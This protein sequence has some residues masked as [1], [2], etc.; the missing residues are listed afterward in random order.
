M[1]EQKQ[2]T[3]T[4]ENKA[5]V[6]TGEPT[7]RPPET[8]PMGV[9]L[10]VLERLVLLNVLPKEGNFTTIKLLRK[11]RENL[12]FDE[13]ENKALN[14]VQ[15]GDQVTWDVDEAAK[16]TRHIQIGEKMTDLIHDALKKLNDEKKLTDQ[17]LSLYE[18]FVANR[19]E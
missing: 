5:P 15:D 6:D 19:E 10:T 3:T 13:A 9:P 4:P 7:Q 1:E 18:R 12:S 2:E 14:F 8:Q 16:I 11:L 17:H